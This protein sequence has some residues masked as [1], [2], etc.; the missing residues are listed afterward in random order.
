MKMVGSPRV[1]CDGMKGQNYWLHGCMEYVASCLGLDRRYDYWFFSAVAGDSVT[2]LY[3]RDISA[4]VWYLSHELAGDVQLGKIFN[5]IGRK[6]TRYTG[7]TDETRGQFLSQIK[8]SLDHGIPVIARGGSSGNISMDIEYNCIVGYDTEALFYLICSEKSP[9]SVAPQFTELIFV[10]E[11]CADLPAIEQVYRDAVMRV[12]EW[13]TMPSTDSLSFGIQA[14]YD[15]ADSFENGS[16]SGLPEDQPD[17]WNVHGTYLCMLG[18]NGG[19]GGLFERALHD[20]PEMRFIEKI[21]PLYT[22][23]SEIFHIL[24]YRDSRGNNDYA[25]GGMLG[26]FHIARA[27]VKDPI[28]M[29]PVCE[30]IREAAR[31]SEKIVD[32]YRKAASS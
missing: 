26:G 24:A 15:W 19:G 4:P 31:I 3:S 14:F 32:V 22:E 27:S 20:H 12:P 29:K 25:N 1:L 8:T 11:P 9:Q 6:Y 18:T 28:L 2:Q 10:G 17:I 13:L 23:L 30:K 5:A 21:I 16:L 7:I